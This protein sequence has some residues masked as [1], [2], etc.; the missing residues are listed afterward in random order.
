MS[1]SPRARA[2]ERAPSVHDGKFN[3]FVFTPPSMSEWDGEMCMFVK[4]EEEEEEER[5]LVME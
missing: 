1:D 2:R 3:P 4:G 5:L